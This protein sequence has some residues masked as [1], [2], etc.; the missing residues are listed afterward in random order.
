MYAFIKIISEKVQPSYYGLLKA[1]F[2]TMCIGIP[3]YFINKG[4]GTNFFII[5]EPSDFPIARV[6]WDF[7]TPRFGEFGY[8]IGVFLFS[9]LIFNLIY[10]ILVFIKKYKKK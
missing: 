10:F 2:I 3:I 8:A 9:F 6:F 7:L 5:S 1:T 4:F